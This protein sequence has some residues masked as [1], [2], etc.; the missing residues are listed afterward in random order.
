M[1][2]DEELIA[3]YENCTLDP[4]LFNHRQHV[5]V[6]WI[7]LRDAPL[8]AALSRFADSLRR[9]AT[10]VGSPGLYHETITFAFLFL[11]HERMQ[12]GEASTFDEFA[13][14]NPDLFRWKPSILDDYYSAETL[15][16][17]LA[18]RTFVMPDGV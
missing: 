15:A 13:E 6:A 7:C 17:P 2:S 8:L 1:M 10:S 3:S 12:R 14:A 9:F 5:R 11:I 18:R 16:S 4:A